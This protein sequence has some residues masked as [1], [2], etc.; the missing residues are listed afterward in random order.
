MQG[1]PLAA[2]RA[3]AQA[4]VQKLPTSVPVSVIGFGASPSVVSPRSTNRPAQLVFC[5]LPVLII[6][7]IGPAFIHLTENL[8]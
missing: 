1:A 4:F 3:A 5:I 7:V 8:G 6:V 2:A